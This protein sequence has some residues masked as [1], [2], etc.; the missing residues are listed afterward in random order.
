MNRHKHETRFIL[1]KGY[2][3]SQIWR[4][5]HPHKSLIHGAE[6]RR[7]LSLQ[8]LMQHFSSIKGAYRTKG[9]TLSARASSRLCSTRSTTS[10]M[11]RTSLQHV[12]RIVTGSIETERRCRF[13]VWSLRVNERREKGVENLVQGLTTSE[14]RHK[15]LE[16]RHTKRHLRQDGNLGHANPLCTDL[17]Q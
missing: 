9:P 4:S 16:F 12:A 2:Y 6:K 14:S 3:C 8:E 17:E 5:I 10:L 13:S 1:F 11:A 7:G 15:C